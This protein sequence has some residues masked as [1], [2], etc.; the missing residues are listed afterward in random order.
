MLLS[1]WHNC[2]ISWWHWV[3]FVEQSLLSC[4]HLKCG[5]SERNTSRQICNSYFEIH[6]QLYPLK[7]YSKYFLSRICMYVYAVYAYI[8]TCIYVYTLLFSFLILIMILGEMIVYSGWLSIHFLPLEIHPHHRSLNEG[9][10]YVI[11]NGP[12]LFLPF[13]HVCL[14]L[15]SK[16]TIYYVSKCIVCSNAHFRFYK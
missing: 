1:Q 9:P 6:F 12:E 11:T 15:L 13:Y 8:H 14:I 4:F 2:Y 10:F 3:C 7:I 16:V 5:E